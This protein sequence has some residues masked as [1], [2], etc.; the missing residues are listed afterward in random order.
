[1][2]TNTHIANPASNLGGPPMMGNRPHAGGR[3]PGGPAI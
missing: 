1:M 3:L 2:K